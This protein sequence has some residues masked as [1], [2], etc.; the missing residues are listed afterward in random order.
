MVTPQLYEGE[1]GLMIYDGEMQIRE[2]GGMGTMA[3]QYSTSM[4]ELNGSFAL[5]NRYGMQALII[6]FCYISNPGDVAL[7]Q[8]D[9]DAI[10]QSLADSI[11]AYLHVTKE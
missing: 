7:W 5:D 10:L 9:Q 3:G 2:S 11:A 6:R 8:N 1:D 4:R